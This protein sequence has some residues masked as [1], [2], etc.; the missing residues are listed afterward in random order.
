MIIVPAWVII[1]TAVT[2]VVILH[3]TLYCLFRKAGVKGWKAFVPILNILETLKITGRSWYWVILM[4]LPV[5]GF[6][7][8]MITLFDLFYCYNRRRFHHFLL[9]ITFGVYYLAIITLLP[10]TKYLGPRKKGFYHGHILR[11][12]AE[13]IILAIVLV[14]AYIKPFWFETF[15]IPSQSMEGTLVIGDYIMVSKFNYGPRLPI[16]P[17][18]IPFV[19][20]AIG[21][22]ESYYEDFQFE[23]LR[24]PGFSSIYR[25]DVVVFN[26]PADVGRPTDRKTNY[27][28]R[29]IGLPGDTVM[30]KNRVV[31]I[32][33]QPQGLP[34]HAQF[35][36]MAKLNKPVYPEY[37]KDLGCEAP[38]PIQ[39]LTSYLFTANMATIE[40]L[41]KLPV[42]DSVWL[43]MPDG[44][45]DIFPQNDLYPWEQNN[46]G[47]LY[48]PQKGKTF[49]LNAQ[50]I[51]LF[52]RVIR[53]Y[54]GNDLKVNGPYIKINGV[55]TNTYTFKQNYY[56]MMG[57]NRDKSSD[58]RFWGFVP[59]DH[60][61]G[62]AWFIWLSFDEEHHW[63]TDRFF[64]SIE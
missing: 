6:L 43:A 12:W 33:S 40:M 13:A 59:E 49:V 14:S 32:N 8:V 18:A 50:N 35:T 20:N 7:F 10:K 21:N 26:Y 9:G 24:L 28:K 22:S 52:E 48:I 51:K 23:Y 5:I 11:E 46:F 34:V 62:R 58:S 63:R 44:N 38:S 61:V 25:G 55:N 39:D 60:I 1:G 15:N 4:F 36:Y 17:L 37:F 45:H 47:P 3:L 16:T 27:I 19:H 56:F 54:E 41:K 53:V 30:I 64:K 31:Y 57:D 2:T 29:C 42:V